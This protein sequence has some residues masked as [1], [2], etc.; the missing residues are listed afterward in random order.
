MAE[1]RL[2]GPPHCTWVNLETLK[3]ASRYLDHQSASRFFFR[4]ANEHLGQSW[5]TQKPW[6]WPNYLISAKKQL[7]Q[8]QG[9]WVCHDWLKFAMADLKTLRLT[10]VFHRWS[11]YLKAEL[12]F[13]W[14]IY[15]PWGWPKCSI[16]D[17]SGLSSRY[18][19]Q[20]WNTLVSLK[21]LR[22]AMEHLGQSWQT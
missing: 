14:P 2:L 21:V 6:G 18:L 13:P 3:L 11:K 15:K 7:G 22:S 9:S 17:P 20:P 1:M 10:K 19:C 8:P 5:Q 4:S 16:A 12:S